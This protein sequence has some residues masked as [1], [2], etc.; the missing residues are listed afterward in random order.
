LLP[1]DNVVVSSTAQQCN[2]I[3]SSQVSKPNVVSIIVYGCEGK[4]VTGTFMFSIIVFRPTELD[5]IGTLEELLKLNPNATKYIYCTQVKTFA[6]ARCPLHP[7][8]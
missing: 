4:G 2:V 7:T 1:G 8:P 5:I 6:D 3:S